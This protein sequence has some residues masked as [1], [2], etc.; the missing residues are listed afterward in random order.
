MDIANPR[1]PR[2]FTFDVIQQEPELEDVEWY[3]MW[4]RAIFNVEKLNVSTKSLVS[5][6][7]VVRVD[8][9]LLLRVHEV[10]FRY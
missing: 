1:I 6:D 2:F 7:F 9:E 8:H 10:V 4:N 3:R 5:L